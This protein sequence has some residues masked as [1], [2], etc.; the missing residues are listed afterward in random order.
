MAYYAHISNEQYTV[1]DRARL[2]EAR[3]EK[4]VIETANRASDEYA[5]LK[6]A[7]LYI[8]TERICPLKRT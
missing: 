4:D 2:E 6:E 5:D 7:Y 3:R 8:L 1:A